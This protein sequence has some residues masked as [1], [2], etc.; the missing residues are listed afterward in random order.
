MKRSYERINYERELRKADDRALRTLVKGNERLRRQMEAFEFTRRE[1]DRVERQRKDDELNNVRLQLRDQAGSFA[2]KD[3]VIQLEHTLSDRF[4]AQFSQLN[5]SGTEGFRE[6]QAARNAAEAVQRETLVNS[7]TAAEQ[8]GTNR[9]WLI[10]ITVT[11]F[12]SAITASLSFL[13]LLLH[14]IHVY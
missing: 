6:T 1:E 8:A 4:Q 5:Q 7:R 13:A 3:M 9:R 2:T 10:T 11:V 14:L 12:F